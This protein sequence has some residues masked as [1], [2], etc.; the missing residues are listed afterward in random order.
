MAL[1]PILLILNQHQTFSNRDKL[2]ADYIKN[3][4]IFT[5]D[6]PSF[7]IDGINLYIDRLTYVISGFV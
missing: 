7:D 4:G 6:L 1:I 3:T 2:L 5:R